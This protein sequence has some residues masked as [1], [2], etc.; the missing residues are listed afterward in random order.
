MYTLTYIYGVFVFKITFGSPWFFG[1]KVTALFKSFGNTDY[2][3]GPFCIL[4][5]NYV[6]F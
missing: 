5:A 6:L 3:A 1:T 2:V 4:L